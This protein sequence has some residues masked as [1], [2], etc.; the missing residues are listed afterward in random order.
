MNESFFSAV[1]RS[2][3]ENHQD[4]T[5]VTSRSR[6]TLTFKA[7]N[8]ETKNTEVLLIFNSKLNSFSTIVNGRE[9]TVAETEVFQ[10]LP[11]PLGP[12]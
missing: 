10:Q 5:V 6:D 7:T 12:S 11:E 9:P 1:R 2:S 8:H 4:P 3:K